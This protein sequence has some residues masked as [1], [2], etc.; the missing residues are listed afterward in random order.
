M[1]K[2]KNITV[3]GNT[4]LIDVLKK[5]DETEHKL[6]LVIDDTK[7]KIGRASCRERV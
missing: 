4:K 3:H 5:M 2:I 7:F 1:E 6:L